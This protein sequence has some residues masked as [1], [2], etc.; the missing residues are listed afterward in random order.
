[1]RKRAEKKSA[2]NQEPEQ[3][4]GRPSIDKKSQKL[5]KDRVPQK[6]YADYL[7]EKGKEYE[8]RKR[9]MQEQKE[10]SIMEK[11]GLTFK[12]Q[13]LTKGSGSGSKAADKFE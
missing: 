3:Q 2:R 9:E 13:I 12:P 4:L 5:V 6:L 10:K 1:M 8:R 11:E 7:F